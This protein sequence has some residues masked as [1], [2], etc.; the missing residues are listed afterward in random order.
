MTLENRCNK[1]L[2]DQL[3]GL[4]LVYIP[5]KRGFDVDGWMLQSTDYPIVSMIYMIKNGR[6][7]IC[8][9]FVYGKVLHLSSKKNINL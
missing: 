8:V 1:G 5:L 7:S 9:L 6:K 4:F 2:R 3:S